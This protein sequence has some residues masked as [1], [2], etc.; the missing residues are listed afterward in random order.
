M[1]EPSQVTR[2]SGAEPEG[3]GRD[4]NPC[5]SHGGKEPL[6]SVIIPTRNAAA[7]LERCLMSMMA[8]T[9]PNIEVIVVD[10]H[11][12]DGTQEI[13]KRLGARLIVAGKERSQQ[14]NLGS[15]QALGEYFYRTDADFV[16][17]PTLVYE[18]VNKIREGFQAVVV[19]GTSD[20]TVSFWAKVRK[21][22]RD[23]FEGDW[24]HTAACFFTGKAFETV[25]GFNEGLTAFEDYDIH[26]RFL[27]AGYSIGRVSAKAYHLGEPKTLAEL[28]RKYIYY[29]NRKNLV[30]F[31]SQNPGKGLWQISP[32][33]LVYLRKLR[34]FGLYFF[35][36]LVYHYVKYWSAFI[37]F[38][39]S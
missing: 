37:G 28:V 27:R 11:S 21:A 12:K 7:T 6:V 20:P 36:F 10:N 16:F 25:G 31:A 29:G 18:A 24:A 4:R 22:E 39:L 2:L 30:E 33:R 8:Q 32:L 17:D 26:N 15:R 35:P 9:Y 13:A 1:R 34:K 38:V 14:T 5:G 23:C 3:V 19:H